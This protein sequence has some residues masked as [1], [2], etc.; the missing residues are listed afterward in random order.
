MSEPILDWGDVPA[1]G[2]DAN[3]LADTRDDD[4]T[5]IDSLVSQVADPPTA[6]ELPTEVRNVPTPRVAR[7]PRVAMIG[8]TINVQPNQIFQLAVANPYRR[9]F[10]ISVEQ[11]ATV[12]LA[13]T[14]TKVTQDQELFRV[15]IGMFETHEFFTTGDLWVRNTGYDV[16][17][18]IMEEITIEEGR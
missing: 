15:R 18:S 5:V 12:R 1:R 10:V 4:G 8:R 7:P 14:A 9:R 11:E 6:A 3:H 2:S 13:D 16:R 17:Y